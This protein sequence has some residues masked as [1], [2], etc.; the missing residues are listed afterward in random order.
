MFWYGKHFCA[1]IF[2]KREQRVVPPQIIDGR[3]HT[4]VDLDLLNAGI[5]LDIENT[6]GNKQVVVEFLRSANVQDRVGVA[7]KL[8]NLLQ[9]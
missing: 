2:T 9:R 7:I 6:I 1:D 8:S 3:S 5:A 4:L